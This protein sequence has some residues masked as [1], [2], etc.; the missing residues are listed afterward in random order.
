MLATSPVIERMCG[1]R[2]SGAIYGVTRLS[3][4]PGALPL[5]RF[6]LDPVRPVQDLANLGMSPQGMTLQPDPDRI[7]VYNLLDYV[8]LEYPNMWDYLEEGRRHGFSFLIPK[9]LD[10]SKITR[11]SRRLLVHGRAVLTN[12]LDFTDA[13]LGPCPTGSH[14]C[15]N[16]GGQLCVGLPLEA[17]SGGESVLDTGMDSL[18]HPR[19]VIRHLPNRHNPTTTYWGWSQPDDIQP[20]WMAGLFAWLPITGIEV[21]EDKESSTHE[22]ALALLRK[23]GID[24]PTS[25]EPM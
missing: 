4:D 22:K 1:Y 9:T 3:S 10:F 15:A 14:V 7:G 19:R 20:K 12:A 8:G 24:L 16:Q 18:A 13:R 25:L 5:E 6:L 2:K 21:I 17:I 23:A 11:A